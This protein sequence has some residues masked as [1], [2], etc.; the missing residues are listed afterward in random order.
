MLKKN[1]KILITIGVVIAAAISI[2][3]WFSGGDKESYVCPIRE[4]VPQIEEAVSLNWITQEFSAKNAKLYS[5]E[6]IF[7]NIADEEGFLRP[8]GQAADNGG[9]AAKGIRE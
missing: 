1:K 7:G 5:L 2:Y 9:H 4:E 8:G 6:F 3:I